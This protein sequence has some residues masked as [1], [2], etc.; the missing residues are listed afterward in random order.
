VTFFV[1]LDTGANLAVIAPV[2]RQ[3]AGLQED[4]VEKMLFL[5]E[6][7][8]HGVPLVKNSRNTVLSSFFTPGSESV[9]FSMWCLI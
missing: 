6:K 5:F 2:E 4:E 1:Q 9:S 8:Y 7:S 3:F